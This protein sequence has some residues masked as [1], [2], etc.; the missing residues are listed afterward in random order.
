VTDALPAFHLDLPGATTS[1]P[2]A[3]RAVTRWLAGAPAVT[4]DDVAAIRLAV[5]ETLANAVEHGGGA[6]TLTAI[7]RHG[8]VLTVVRDRGRWPTADRSLTAGL[9]P[10]TAVRGRGLALLGAYVDEVEVVATATGSS[11][12]FVRHLG[13]PARATVTAR[14]R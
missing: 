9:A 11:V 5:T 10:V 8:S 6:V 2:L 14:D 1:V 7:R 13:A 12:A 3:R 4:E